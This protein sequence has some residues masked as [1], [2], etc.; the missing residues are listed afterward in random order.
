MNNESIR[1]SKIDTLEDLKKLL[2]MIIIRY[3]EIL[4]I[5]IIKKDS[6]YTKYWSLEE[7]YRSLDNI[8]YK[9]I[10]KVRLSILSKSGN[11]IGLDI[12]KNEQKMVIKQFE[13]FNNEIFEKDE[14]ES[15][16]KLYEQFI[17]DGKYSYYKVDNKYLVRYNPN[18]GSYDIL[19]N[20]NWIND[21]SI[22]IWFYDSE[23]EIELLKKNNERMV[24]F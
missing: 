23:H 24:K 9:N 22:I 10:N 5:E 1:I 20:N 21:N 19:N 13:S 11:S 3:G 8:S 12:Y 15:N 18:E 2:K 4:S 6:T 14:N 7:I 17:M 16:I